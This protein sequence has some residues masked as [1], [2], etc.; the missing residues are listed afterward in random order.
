MLSFS[1]PA[2]RFA[3][4]R[5]RLWMADHVSDVYLSN[6]CGTNLHSGI[7]NDI[8]RMPHRISIR[9]EIKSTFVEIDDN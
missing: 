8:D 7:Y 9:R 5:F 1:M 6:A 4:G 2:V 3:P